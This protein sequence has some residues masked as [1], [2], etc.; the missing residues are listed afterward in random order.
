M[1]EHALVT[2]AAKRIGKALALHLAGQGFSVTV[3]YN[4]SEAEAQ[5]LV[6]DIQADGGKATAIQADLADMKAVE[7]LEAQAAAQFGPVTLLVNN[8]STFE[9]DEIGSITAQSWDHHLQPNL[10]APVFLAQAMAARLPKDEKGL[11]INMID[12]RVW[13]LTPR[14][15]SYTLSKA[16][17]W[18]ATQT[19]AQALAPNI[20]VNGIGP[21]PTLS[22]ARQSDSDFQAQVNATIL[23]VQ[24]QLSEITAAIDFI[25]NAPSMTG[26]M[27]ALDSGQHLAWE[28]PDVVGC[29]E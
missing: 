15:M 6:A 14:Y 5:Q 21:G 4:N 27:L 13:A 12:Q 19:L 8:A 9:S 2:G 10:Q 3:H 24:P 16:A 17:L 7:R 28:T 11:I 20:R 29:F 18:S 25:R 26:Q 22:N 23:K 1:S